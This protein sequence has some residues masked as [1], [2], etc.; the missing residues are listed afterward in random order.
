MNEVKIMQLYYKCIQIYRKNHN[1][2]YPDNKKGGGFLFDEI[3]KHPDEYGLPARKDPKDFH[4]F[5][6]LFHNFVNPDNQYADYI[7][8]NPENF[9]MT[10]ILLSRNDGSAIGSPKRE[11]TRDIL[12]N[13]SIYY[14]A[15]GPSPKDV[16]RMPNPVGFYVVLWDD[17]EIEKIP[18]DQVLYMAVP[19]DDS[20]TGYGYKQVFRNEAGLPGDCMTYEQMQQ[21]INMN[22]HTNRESPSIGFPL[23]P[24]Q[25]EPKPDNGGIE[26]LVILKRL[27]NQPFDREQIWDSL[28]HQVK[29]FTLDDLQAGAAKLK[30]PLEKKTISLDEL[31]KLHT[32]A[33]LHLNS[34]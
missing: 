14:H 12:A 10:L 25:T 18:Y 26:S 4:E 11:G 5:D 6:E 13:T 7:P 27:E 21:T 8:G 1:G 3:L 34:V 20:A 9:A 17:G 32:P 31:Q 15:N 16:S 28:G 24:G 2:S 22:M 23:T 30:F 19:S 33:I 29:D